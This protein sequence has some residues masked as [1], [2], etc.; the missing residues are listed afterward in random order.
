MKEHVQI[1]KCTYGITDDNIV[2]DS[3][4]CDYKGKKK[5]PRLIVGNYCSIGVNSKFFLG[6]T[7]PWPRKVSMALIKCPNPPDGY[8]TQ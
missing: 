3:V 7:N 1:G 2:W 5:Q 4:E 6:L 8:Q